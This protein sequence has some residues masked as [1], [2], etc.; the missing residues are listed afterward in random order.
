MKCP[1]CQHVQRA[2]SGMTCLQCKYRYVFNPKASPKMTDNRFLA[3][4]RKAAN[5]ETGF[6]TLNQLY[7]Q[8]YRKALTSKWTSVAAAAF[9]AIPLTAFAYFIPKIGV[10]MVALG[11]YIVAFAFLFWVIEKASA[12]LPREEFEK[13]F[14][15]PWEKAK[16]TLKNLIRKPRLKEPP[17]EARFADVYDYGVERILVVSRDILVDL[18][19]LNGW[20]T[21]QRALIISES[22][23]P[24]YL[25][26]Q[27]N[28]LLKER[29]DLPVYTLHDASKEGETMAARLKRSRMLALAEHPVIDLGLSRADAGKFKKLRHAGSGGQE[30]YIPV[31]ALP[32]G[33]LMAG[34]TAAVLG[35]VAFAE[36]LEP[37]KMQQSEGMHGAL[38]FG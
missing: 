18:F 28:Q 15:G 38:H 29:P 25:R 24:K 3:I 32:R 1:Q 37:R 23:Y 13:K 9:L 8:Y 14:L 27:A 21:E 19:V 35:G 30:S 10:P 26:K 5:G 20:H 11:I 36:L 6:F 34:L 16:G 22:G 17:E 2:R 12:P 4:L 31:D 7:M 33:M